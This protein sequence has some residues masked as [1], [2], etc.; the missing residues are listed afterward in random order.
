MYPDLPRDLCAVLGA[1]VGAVLT[2]DAARQVVSQVL[3]LVLD[4]PLPVHEVMPERVGNYMLAAERLCAVLREVEPMH[5]AQ[6]DETEGYRHAQAL[7]VDYPRMLTA[8][9]TGQYLLLT[10]RRDGEMV[11]HMGLN[12]ATSRHTQ[13]LVATE[14]TLYIAPAHR[15]VG[16]LFPRFVAFGER[17]ARQF[18]VREIRLST[19]L[20]NQSHGLM[21]RLG[22][23]PVAMV[24]CKQIGEPEHV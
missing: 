17:V 9:A 21:Q 5:R 24:L 18:G 12:I 13:M 15:A 23:A 2:P 14:D 10:V 19:K 20:V 22:Y 1:H 4:D 3:D 6:W 7:H 11:G 16:R 8:E